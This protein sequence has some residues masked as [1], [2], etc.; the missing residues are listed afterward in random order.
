MLYV[1][2]LSPPHT[3]TCAWQVL[4]IGLCTPKEITQ[5]DATVHE[6]VWVPLQAARS[7]LRRRR[8]REPPPGTVS[9]T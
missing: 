8:T 4:E 2:H 1:S 3:L 7:S 5:W 6:E 9:G